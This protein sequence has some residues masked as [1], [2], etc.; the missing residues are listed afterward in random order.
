MDGSSESE[1]VVD[2]SVELCDSPSVLTGLFQIRRASSQTQPNVEPV[3]Q[4]LEHKSGGLSTSP[5][6]SFKF[7][8]DKSS[9]APSQKDG[10]SVDNSSQ[11]SEKSQS[12]FTQRIPV[13]RKSPIV[14]LC[15]PV[16][17]R[18]PS[19]KLPRIIDDTSSSTDTHLSE[20]PSFQGDHD[21]VAYESPSRGLLPNQ[22]S[23]IT[24]FP[25]EQEITPEPKHLHLAE[26]KQSQATP[27]H[28]SPATHESPNLNQETHQLEVLESAPRQNSSSL[29]EATYP[30]VPTSS[31][32]Q[33]APTPMT[34]GTTFNSSLPDPTYHSSEFKTVSSN[35][36]SGLG[37]ATLPYCEENREVGASQRS[38]D[39]AS[40][41]EM[42]RMQQKIR[43]KMSSKDEDVKYA[44][45]I[46]RSLQDMQARLR[47]LSSKQREHRQQLG[48]QLKQQA[49]TPGSQQ[50][51]QEARMQLQNMTRRQQQLLKLLQSHKELAA[52][53]QQMQGTEHPPLAQSISSGKSNTTKNSNLQ[54]GKP[55]RI[56]QTYSGDDP[57]K[58]SSL[59]GQEAILMQ[60]EKE[61]MSPSSN[62][63]STQV[64][65][66]QTLSKPTPEITSTRTFKPPFKAH[67][68]KRP[69][70]LK[71]PSSVLAD[72][73]SNSTPKPGKDEVKSTSAS[74]P[75]KS[76]SIPN[77]LVR[78]TSVFITNDNRRSPSKSPP[79]SPLSG[80]SNDE[81][82]SETTG[83][84]VKEGTS[85][86]PRGKNQNE[87]PSQREASLRTEGFSIDSLEQDATTTTLDLAAVL[88]NNLPDKRR[89]TTMTSNV[90]AINQPPVPLS[91]DPVS[92][93]PR[94]ATPASSLQTDS[95]SVDCMAQQSATSQR[96]ET[97]SAHPEK[98]LCSANL[99][100]QT[101]SIKETTPLVSPT[102]APLAISSN[103]VSEFPQ[104]TETIPDN[105]QTLVNQ[106]TSIQNKDLNSCRGTDTSGSTSASSQPRKVVVYKINASSLNDPGTMFSSKSTLDTVVSSVSTAATVPTTFHVENVG[107]T[108]LLRSN[109]IPT[110]NQRQQ[111]QDQSLSSS[112][113]SSA[114]TQSQTPA[115]SSFSIP[116]STCS[117]SVPRA[118]VSTTLF[119]T[120]PH[121][122]ISTKTGRETINNTGTK[123]Q[124]SSNL[125]G[126]P[127][128]HKKAASSK[129][130]TT[131]GDLSSQNQ[132]PS[133]HHNPKSF[134]DEDDIPSLQNLLQKGLINSGENVLSI[135]L[136]RGTVNGSLNSDGTVCPTTPLKNAT[137]GSISLCHMVSLVKRKSLNWIQQNPSIWKSVLYKGKPLDKVHTDYKAL[138]A[139]DLQ[140]Q[141]Q[142]NA[143][144]KAT[145][146]KAA[147]TKTNTLSSIQE[148]PPS[149]SNSG[150]AH[151]TPPSQRHAPASTSQ[152]LSTGTSSRGTA[153]TSRGHDLV[154]L[155][156]RITTSTAQD[157]NSSVN[158]GLV[159]SMKKILLISDDELVPASWGISSNF[160]STDFQNAAIAPEWIDEMD[161]WP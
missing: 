88:H 73:S 6:F 16:F 101:K 49:A 39:D 160:R 125:Q 116:S 29:K 32:R 62:L 36:S 20:S 150:S 30:S 103:P 156:H 37:S 86:G 130:K 12:I 40:L 158:V 34:T 53:L 65:K 5:D 23:S 127:E 98:F 141:S 9:E 58:K 46:R 4:V 11:Q 132:R 75:D 128:T 60:K 151:P 159:S 42:E 52:S 91:S 57:S 97:A 145:Q 61:V 124:T 133:S 35:S 138:I 77:S 81:Y 71:S 83:L 92:K 48:I 118:I 136:K 84:L 149:R 25:S 45:K 55:A 47:H 140:L 89:A 74:V 155:G 78:D 95:I 17:A 100:A 122:K 10:A 41:V 104:T 94:G 120:S 69:H 2:E 56:A 24:T 115:T 87:Q 152:D 79:Y 19:L 121:S 76:M 157:V 64:S 106:L 1:T 66:T 31:Q 161:V 50:Q 18:A 43:E 153:I 15:S 111:R 119:T 96:T 131:V 109:S 68:T 26:L 59:P 7:N 72:S 114:L 70:Q 108:T 102:K 137:S 22:Q 80:M 27:L 99:P 105:T 112:N 139:R 21:Q 154:T 90:S 142:A 51:Q 14:T 110:K 148:S 85:D 8:E 38:D 107:S 113:N 143:G 44:D 126:T 67:P 54:E 146:A 134:S 28:L 33:L 63:L 13:K 3:C 147:T 129:A 117:V 144:K 123:S 82:L 135:K 93:I